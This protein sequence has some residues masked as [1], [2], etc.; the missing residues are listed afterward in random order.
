[1]EAA[2]HATTYTQKNKKTMTPKERFLNAVLK[3]QTDMPAL[4]SA[5]SVIS[6]EVMDKAGVFFPEA[7]LDADKMARLAAAGHT[8]LGFDNVM[9]LFSV[10]HDTAA[11]GVAINWGAKDNMPSCLAPI[12]KEPD[13]IVN[14]DAFLDSPFARTPLK[15]IRLLRREFKDRVAI[16]GKVFGP[17]TLGY[18][19]F[20]LETFLMETMLAPDKVRKIIERLKV[21]T[22]KFARAQIEAGVDS[23]TVGDH[24]TR[25][26]CGPDA[27]RDFILPVHSEF[28]KTISVPILLHIC[29]DTSDRV[30]YIN[31]TGIPCFHWDSKSGID[32]IAKLASPALS[33]MG[34]T[35]N[36]LLLNGSAPEVY[37]DIDD[38]VK[39]KIDILGPECAVPL[40]APYKNLACFKEWRKQH[41]GKTR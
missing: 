31:Q 38:K 11:C 34:G 24:A 6:T 37:A 40:N 33:L 20:G 16:T 30:Q 5:T 4:G 3:K 25:D 29:G 1:L 32:K 28:A 15:A 13:D 9:P 39:H 19:F 2:L 14:G 18:H 23:I 12:W 22:L 8:L 35:S 7:H 21:I 26:L 36:M 41:Y 10:C 27:Y 17:W